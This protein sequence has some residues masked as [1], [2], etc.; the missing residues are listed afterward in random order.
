MKIQSKGNKKKRRLDKNKNIYF[1]L[2]Y[3]SRD[4][5]EKNRTLTNQKLQKGEIKMKNVPDRHK[6]RIMVHPKVALFRRHGFLGGFDFKDFAKEEFLR[7]DIPNGEKFLSLVHTEKH[8]RKVK[9]ACEVKAQLAEMQLTPECYEIACLGVGT[10]ILASEEGN[11]GIQCMTGHHAGRESAMG[12]NLFNSMAIAIQRLVNQG[13]KVCIIDIDGH[14]GNGTQNIFYDTDQV[15]FCSMHQKDAFP[16]T[17]SEKEIGK[18][19]G[20][21]YTLNIP[22]PKGSGDSVFIEAL[23]KIVAKAV[24][25]K[26][27]IVGIYAGF[28]G[29][30]ADKLLELNYSLKGFYECGKIIS[31]NF[32]QVFASLGGGYHQDPTK[33][34]FAFVAGINQEEFPY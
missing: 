16:G 17:G 30:Y 23:E 20:T 6:M 4:I 25:F 18:G 3:Y 2:N 7:S 24:D 29:Y 32:K 14:H 15:L 34:I 27:D 1:G 8:I 31:Q 12:F 22:L 11:F 9:K 21:G 19:K 28:D 26:P 10:V 13:K 33:C 5:K